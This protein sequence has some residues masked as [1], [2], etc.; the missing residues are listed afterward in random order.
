[1]RKVGLLSCEIFRELNGR[2]FKDRK[3]FERAVLDVFN[4]HLHDVPPGYSYMNLIAWGEENEWVVKAGKRGY[5]VFLMAKSG[6]NNLC[7]SS[8]SP[9][10]LTHYDVS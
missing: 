3:T 9:F 7:G 4:K 2:A 6:F 5:A 1:M 10:Y 8:E